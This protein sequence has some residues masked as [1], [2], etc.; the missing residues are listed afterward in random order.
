MQ[1]VLLKVLQESETQ[2]LSDTLARLRHYQGFQQQNVSA[3][4]TTG[5]SATTNLPQAKLTVTAP[6]IE[7]DGVLQ[8]LDETDYGEF[9]EVASGLV[10]HSDDYRRKIAK[11]FSSTPSNA[12]S[13]ITLSASTPT[14]AQVSSPIRK[15]AAIALL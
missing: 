1:L 11:S 4:A 6:S 15:N 12:N 7:S 5:D 9:E 14:G 10:V 8:A 13:S 2:V 3:L